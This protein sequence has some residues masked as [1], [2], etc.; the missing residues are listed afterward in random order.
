MWCR[1]A[2][3][4][5]DVRRPDI[6]FACPLPSNRGKLSARRFVAKHFPP[7]LAEDQFN[8]PHCGV[9]AQQ[10]WFLI[11]GRVGEW[12]PNLD[13]PPPNQY[14]KPEPKSKTYGFRV[15][16]I[17]H[18]EGGKPYG[19]VVDP[20]AKFI[21]Q[22]GDDLALHGFYVSM[23]T[24]CE[25]PTLWRGK[26]M[27][28]PA[29]GEVE[30]PNADLE[31]TIKRDY[32]EAAAIV[33]RSPRGAAALLRLCLQNLF[34]QLGLGQTS[35]NDA[36]KELVKRGLDPDIQKAL[37]SVR[38]IGNNAVH[39]GEIELSDSPEIALQLFALINYIAEQMITFKQKREEIFLSLPEGAKKQ[40]KKRDGP[41]NS[42]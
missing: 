14:T 28:F 33:G 32:N 25:K 9:Y 19:V 7:Q 12:V 36:I 31:D 4:R 10:I 42:G 15:Q 37:D 27:L 30:A 16:P 1:L 18:Y 39:P 41:S 21:P 40:I 2:A 34:K 20:R 11:T 26:E 17:R 22:S 24:R 13:F 29:L 8:C 38:V 3:Q 5:A 35:S 6:R 23:C